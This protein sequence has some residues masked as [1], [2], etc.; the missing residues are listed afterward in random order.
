LNTLDLQ[1]K[2]YTPKLRA[3]HKGALKILIDTDAANWIAVNEFGAQVLSNIN[4]KSYDELVSVMAG[5]F[6][7]RDKFE[8]RLKS[9]LLKCGKR[10][11]LSNS[12]TNGKTYNGRKGLIGIRNLHEMWII[13]NFSCNLRCKHCYT[14][15]RV[16]S[17]KDMLD[18]DEIKSIVD[19]ARELG[20]QVFYFTGGEPFLRE[21]ILDL[22][23]YVTE[24]SKLILFTNGT[25]ITKETARALAKHKERL[26]VQVSI[27]GHNEEFNSI[28]RNKGMFE[29]AMNGIKH[30]LEEGIMVGVSSTPVT[31]TKESVP[32]LTELLGNM[33]TNGNSVKYHHLIYLICFGNALKYPFTTLTN[34]ELSMVYDRCCEVKKEL[35]KK[36][37]NKTLKIT[38]GKIFDAYATNGPKKDLCGAGYTILAVDNKGSLFPCASTISEPKYDAG[39][40]VDENGRY[41]KGKLKELW[42]GSK[43]LDEVRGY[44]IMRREGEPPDD[45]RF[46][47]GGGCW[48]NMKDPAG[49][50]SKEHFFAKTY[51]E[52]TLEAIKKASTEDVDE[53]DIS[54]KYP[55]ILSYMSR[56]RIACAGMRKTDDKSG[57]GLDLG[58]CICFS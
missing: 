28:I 8:E 13:T 41:I 4:G 37:I 49:S 34:D 10:G 43:K 3:E 23:A 26:I 6:K 7:N 12:E 44:S 24:R 35:K 1:K 40:L 22:A 47:H 56:E 25:L 33:K 58:Y 18:S 27:E 55:K 17:E 20:V 11:F 5:G 16:S 46:F 42:Y 21:D 14:M 36:K 52:K 54:S 2:L 57:D 29:R 53:D 15:D 32:K 48:Y 30:L 45:L 9:F 51:E 50:F 39:R 31:A 38:N 19:E